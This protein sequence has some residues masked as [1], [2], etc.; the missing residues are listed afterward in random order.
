[1]QAGVLQPAKEGEEK[2]DVIVMDMT[3]LTLGIETVGGVMT[4]IISKGVTYPVKKAKVFSTYQ[5]DQPS[6]TIQVYQGERAMTKHNLQM[7]SFELSGIDPAPRGT[8]QIEVTFEVDSN[9]LLK[10]TAEDKSTGTKNELEVEVKGQLSEEEIEK[11]R[12]DAEEF[13][14]KDGLIRQVV[15]ARNQLESSALSLKSTLGDRD[16]LEGLPDEDLDTLN[17][18]AD[19]VLSWLEDNPNDNMEDLDEYLEDLKEHQVEFDEI[20]QPIL[21]QTGSSDQFDDSD[22]HDEL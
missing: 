9:G 1:V 17:E 14:E 20:V 2:P 18:A 3:A 19:D 11:M 22:D 5:D 16:K 10:V 21:G 15:E 6:V 4:P 12:A 13:A 7:G 8:P